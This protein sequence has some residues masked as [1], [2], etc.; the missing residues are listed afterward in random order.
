MSFNISVSGTI[1]NS[2]GVHDEVVAAA[3][4]GGSDGIIATV[5]AGTFGDFSAAFSALTDDLNVHANSGTPSV[6][7][8]G[9]VDNTAGAAQVV[10]HLKPGAGPQSVLATVAAGGTGSFSASFG[11]D[12]GK[13]TL[14]N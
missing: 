6:S 5:A 7:V 3:Q 2:T 8:S 13:V 12:G 14:S 1:D 4:G 10:V 11:A 9:A